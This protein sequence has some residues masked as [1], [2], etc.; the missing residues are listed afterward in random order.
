MANSF[1]TMALNSPQAITDW[2]A[3]SE[4]SNHM[5]PSTGNISSFRSPNSVCPSSIIA[6]SI[7]CLSRR[8]GCS[9]PVLP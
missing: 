8:L 6:H 1:S 5:T 4:A 7:G 2:V 3:D 9:W